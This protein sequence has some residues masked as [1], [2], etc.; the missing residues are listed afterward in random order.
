VA[1]AEPTAKK[2]AKAAAKRVEKADEQATAKVERKVERKSEGKAAAPVAKQGEQPWAGYD[3]QTV[4]EIRK[5]LTTANEQVRAE[6]RVY[7]SEHKQRHGVLD[8]TGS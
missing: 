4:V 8:A 2:A 6:V 5:V 7:E 1:K 3:E